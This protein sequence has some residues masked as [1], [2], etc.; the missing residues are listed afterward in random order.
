MNDV[1]RGSQTKTRCRSKKVNP[2]TTS[3]SIGRRCR[4]RHRHHRRRD[5]T[6]AAKENPLAFSKTTTKSLLLHSANH[7]FSIALCA[8]STIVC[9]GLFAFSM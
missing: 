5:L 1:D 9:F 3:T 8:S 2:T 6:Q 7:D 4:C